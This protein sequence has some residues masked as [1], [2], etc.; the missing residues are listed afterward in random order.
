[1]IQMSVNIPYMDHLGMWNQ[2]VD[3]RDGG[4]SHDFFVCELGRNPFSR[5]KVSHPQWLNKK[6]HPLPHV[7][8]LNPTCSC[9]NPFQFIYPSV[10]K[11]AENKSRVSIYV[12][13]NESP[14]ETVVFHG[15]PHLLSVLPQGQSLPISLP[16]I[17]RKSAPLPCRWYWS[18][19]WPV[20]W[21]SR[22]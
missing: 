19:N 17:G 16:S 3:Q 20:R 14:T 12:W 2:V 9:S 10:N 22:A 13:I 1:M 8:R 15:F 11:H 5:Q 18:P 4:I 7:C 21:G 6:T